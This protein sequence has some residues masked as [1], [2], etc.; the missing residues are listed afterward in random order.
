M[1]RK[2]KDGKKINIQDM[3]SNHIT[4]CI[5]LLKRKKE[6]LEYCEYTPCIWPSSDRCMNLEYM[7]AITEQEIDDTQHMINV[8]N[9]ELIER[10]AH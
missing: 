3:S 8:F 9:N 7:N 6:E 2:T 5:N 4:N 10:N 1:K